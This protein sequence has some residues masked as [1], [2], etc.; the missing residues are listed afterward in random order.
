MPQALLDLPGRQGVELVLSNHYTLAY[1]NNT[2]CGIATVVVTG[3][4]GY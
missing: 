3:I 4:N 1:L 2:A